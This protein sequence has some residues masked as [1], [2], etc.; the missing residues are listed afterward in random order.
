MPFQEFSDDDIQAIISF[1]RSQPPAK[2]EVP[3]I[4]FAPGEEMPEQDL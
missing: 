1:L 3:E 2:N 4:V